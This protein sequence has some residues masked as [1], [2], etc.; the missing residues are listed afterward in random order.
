MIFA[1]LFLILY[2]LLQLLVFVLPTGTLPSAVSSAFQSVIGYMYAFNT[3]FPIDTLISLGILGVTL[4]GVVLLWKL[5][6]FV[7][8]LVRGGKHL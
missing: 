8:G 4:E 2:G 7:V 5:V 6:L 1:P 3:I